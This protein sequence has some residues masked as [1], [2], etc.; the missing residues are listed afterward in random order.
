MRNSVNSVSTFA[1]FFIVITHNSPLSFKPIH[2]LLCI[3]GSNVSPNFE[4]FVC[5]GENLPN[6]SYNFANHKSSFL[7]IL[8]H[9][10]VS[11]NIAPLYLFRSNIICFGQ[12]QP[13]KCKFLRLSSSGVKSCQ[14]L[15][16]NFETISQFL[17]RFF[18]ILQCHTCNSSVSCSSCIFYVEQKDPIENTNFATFKCSDENL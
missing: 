6:S 18:D 12:K 9:T 17:F 10:L 16:V 3:K 1:S 8:H 15:Y 5:S 4:N 14:I 2:F 11:R 7:Q 13:L